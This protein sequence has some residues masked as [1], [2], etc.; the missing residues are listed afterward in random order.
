V[1][2]LL[3]GLN[4][5]P[6][7]IGVALYTA[8]LCEDLVAG[9][10]E[11]R[12]VAAKP[13]YPEWKVQSAFAG[14]WRLTR[15]AG[16]EVVRCPIYVPAK[17]TGVRRLLHHASFAI[18]AIW[19]MAWAARTFKPDLVITVAPSIIAAPVA[20]VA[21]K[22]ARAR[23]WLHVQDFEVEAA[24][25]TGLLDGASSAARL[26][27]R[28]EGAIIALFDRV[29]SISPEMCRKLES[30]G[31]GTRQA[32]ELRN[33]ADAIAVQPMTAPSSFRTEW[34][35]QAPNIALY[36]GNIANKQGIE[37]VIEAAQLLR[38]RRDLAFVIC[39][40]GP[41]RAELERKARGLDNVLFRDLQPVERLGELLG[42][43][44]VHLL[45]QRAE[46][47]D[48]VLPS[49]LT[50]M[51]A[52]GRPTIATVRAGTGLARELEGCGIVTEP[53]DAPAFAAAL[54]RLISDVDLHRRL[55]EAA[56]ERAKE[57]WDRKKII[58]AFQREIEQLVSE[59]ALR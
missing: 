39:G 49:K 44:S 55:S 27:R 13:Y 58:G 21:A 15:E 46:A 1:R 22:M 25:A 16:V 2:I 57:R 50:N 23:S 6:E 31:A 8:G 12:V 29:S 32:Y 51:L 10:H 17:P 52:S 40:Q 56:Q 59:P 53:E 43:A 36:S 3:L 33:W 38:N 30:Y 19:P 7:P 34:G 45:P 20:W 37:I 41:N 18:S 47:A 28:L 54:E 14:G 5:A 11:V 48:L 9:G 42:L 35:I 24:F 4:Y 26:A